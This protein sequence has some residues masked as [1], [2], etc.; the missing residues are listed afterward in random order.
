MFLDPTA[1]ADSFTETLIEP[2]GRY[3][4]GVTSETGRLTDVL[5]S[6]PANLEIVPCNAVSLSS[7]AN[8]LSCCTETATRQHESM[9]TLLQEAGVRCHFVPPAPGMPDLTFTRDAVVMSP[10]GL[11]TLRPAARHRQAEAEYVADTLKALG[12][13]SLGAVEEGTVEG[14]DVCIV[15]PGLVVIGYSGERTTKAGA[16]AL[17]RMFERFG[18]E[19]VYP[20]LDPHYLHLDTQFTMLS[21]D[22]AVGCVES[23]GDGFVDRMTGLGIDIVPASREEVGRLGANLLSLGLG[24]IIAPAGNDRLN[25]LLESIG[26]EIIEVDVDQ[27]TRCGGGVHCLTMPLARQPD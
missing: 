9:A 8:G 17:G 21:S 24:S 25:R 12:I 6:A 19:V 14:G 5:L 18:W 3:R 11:V 2:K 15:R 16:R 22:W 4:W 7:A 1:S 13:P 27:F 10:W 23:L 26:F 20:C